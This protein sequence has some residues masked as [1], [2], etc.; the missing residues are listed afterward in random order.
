MALATYAD[1]LTQ[2]ANWLK[3]AD[4]TSN[5]P[6][7]VVLAESKINKGLRVRQMETTMATVMASGV[8]AVPT[9][10]V[11]LKDAYISSTTP[12]GDL[13]RKTAEFVYEKY[14]NRV[15]DKQPIYIAREG[16]N[17]IFGPYPDANYT[18]TFVYYN[19][20]GALVN[21]PNTVY[22]SYPGLWLFGALAEA[23]PFLRNDSR[24]ALWQAK[25]KEL[26]DAVQDESDDEYL[27]GDVLQIVAG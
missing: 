9:N 27:S 23:A 3:R 12:Y 20:L 22:T 1:L 16:N 7:F 5:I 8:I 18:V 4:L 19:R 25:F 6:D 2:T 15:A 14:P 10:Y 21:G 17:F 11:A 26:M 13:A 24:V